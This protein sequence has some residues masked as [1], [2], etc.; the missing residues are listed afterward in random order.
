MSVEPIPA[1]Y[2]TIT[3]YLIVHDA[4]AAIEFYTRAFHAAELTRLAD[5]GGK[6]HHAEIEIGDSRIMLAD[7]FPERHIRGPKSLGGTAVTI[8]LYVPDVD[9]VAARAL[10]A[11]ARLIRPVADQFYGDRNGMLEDPFGHSW[12]VSTHVEDVSDE[13]V[14]RRAAAQMA[15][16]QC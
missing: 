6:I 7:E 15:Q 1:G 11:G 3:P 9:A 8:H 4:R 13:E 16:E 2:H 14:R 12:A 10:D 5:P